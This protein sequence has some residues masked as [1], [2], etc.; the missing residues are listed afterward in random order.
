MV[1]FSRFPNAASIIAESL[2][3]MIPPSFSIL[4]LIF[5]LS[6][7]TFLLP[8]IV[9]ENSATAEESLWAIT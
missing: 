6:K 5:T 2:I 9:S 8:S 4:T 7:V 1:E 3:S